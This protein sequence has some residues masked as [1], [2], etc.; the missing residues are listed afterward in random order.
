MKNLSIVVAGSGEIKDLSIKP[1]TKVSDI[2]RDAELSGYVLSK[3]SE[4]KPF[5]QDDEI[6]PMVEDGQKIYASTPAYAGR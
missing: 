5:N 3:N 6:Y 4:E 2:I 1:G